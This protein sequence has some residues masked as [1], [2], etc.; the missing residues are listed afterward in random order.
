MTRDYPYRNLL[1]GISLE[2]LAKLTSSLW[3]DRRYIVNTLTGEMYDG[4]EH[5]YT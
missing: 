3:G 5:T 4:F 1:K 2:R